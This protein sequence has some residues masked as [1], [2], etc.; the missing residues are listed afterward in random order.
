MFQE[1]SV[2][3]DIVLP[4]PVLP[5]SISLQDSQPSYTLGSDG[6]RILDNFTISW[7]PPEDPYG[8]IVSYAVYVGPRL[9]EGSETSGFRDRRTVSSFEHYNNILSH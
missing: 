5:E 9:L 7:S 1:C 6:R 2:V 3:T 4:G 8:E